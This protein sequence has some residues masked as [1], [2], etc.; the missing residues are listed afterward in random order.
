V[1]CV[2]PFSFT[3][4][5]QA[6]WY[7]ISS[8]CWLPGTPGSSWLSVLAPGMHKGWGWSDPAEHWALVGQGA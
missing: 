6:L 5:W 7:E 1:G 2:V 8:W 4:I 3:Q